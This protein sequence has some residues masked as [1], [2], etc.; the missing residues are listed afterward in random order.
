[1]GGGGAVK[2]VRNLAVFTDNSMIAV[3]RGVDSMIV[4]L[5]RGKVER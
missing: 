3:G 4:I 2:M 5:S 1:L